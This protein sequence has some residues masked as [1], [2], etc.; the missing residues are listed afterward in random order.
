MTRHRAIVE[1]RVTH[2]NGAVTD[3]KNS[4]TL[5]SPV[6]RLYTHAT[7][8]REPWH[9]SRVFQYSRLEYE[10]REEKSANTKLSSDLT[11]ARQSLDGLASSHEKLKVEV[12][13]RNVEFH[14][15]HT[16][17]RHGIEDSFEMCM[18]AWVGV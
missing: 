15:W 4:V 18:L 2:V 8:N 13:V 9:G 11:S 10:L 14:L 7:S 5:L 17:H 3:I 1:A 16:H 12:S 6:M